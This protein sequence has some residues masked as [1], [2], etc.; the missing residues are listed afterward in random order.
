MEENKYIEIVKVFSKLGFFAFGGPAA[1]IAMMEEEVVDKRQWMSKEEFLD[2]LGFTNLIPGPN[3]TEMA[4]ILGHRRAGKWGLFLAGISFILP[5][6]VIVMIIGHFY[7]LYG[8]FP[9]VQTIMEYIKP[10]IV[11]II[12]AALIKLFKTAIK[13]MSTFIVFC[14]SLLLVVFGASE[15]TVLIVAA[16]LLLLIKKDWN[17]KNYVIEPFSL[18]ILFLTFLKIGLLL[19][20]SGYVLLAFIQSEFVDKLQVLTQVQMIDAISVGEFTPGP[21][22]TTATFIG[23]LL[24]DIPGALVAT[25]GIFLPSFLLVLIL[26]PLFSKLKQS[27][28]FSKM[29]IGINAAALA[30]MANVT[31]QLGQNIFVEWY[32]IL[33]F[34]ISLLGILKYKI[35]SAFFILGG[36]LLGLF[37]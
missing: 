30:L 1:H 36:I 2:L 10:V 27:N 13:D 20:G 33:I 34:F 5:A 15:L 7:K 18:S 17:F 21:V 19:Y 8:D 31:I 3:S 22:F 6:M 16:I 14:L 9:R 25:V 11:A 4:I 35:N 32:F 26:A 37:L 28:T 29:L 23:Y 12:V 24:F